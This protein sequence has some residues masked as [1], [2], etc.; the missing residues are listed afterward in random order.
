MIQNVKQQSSATVHAAVLASALLSLS[1][2]GAPAPAPTAATPGTPEEPQLIKSVFVD[3]P[4]F[5][6]DPFFPNSTRRGRLVETNRVEA[7]ANFN[8]IVLKGISGTAEKRL[9]IINNK[10]F[11]VGEEG[12]LRVG[13][14]ATRIKCVE[15][16]EKSILISINGVT[17]ELFLDTKF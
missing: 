7:V 4:N 16:R 11:E 10:T 14:P 15:I 8:N 17:K 2:V 1:L 3:R 5:G 13:G 9:A 12:D 6:R